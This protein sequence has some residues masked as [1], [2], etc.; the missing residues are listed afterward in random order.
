M[1]RTSL[2]EAVIV[3]S[4]SH[5]VNFV[6]SLKILKALG[7]LLS[8]LYDV[9]SLLLLLYSFGLF[10]DVRSCC[11]NTVLCIQSGLQSFLV[12]EENPIENPA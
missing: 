4:S 7:S 6:F 12:C 1:L 10:V 9:K 3:A 8:I 5:S 2:E 11:S